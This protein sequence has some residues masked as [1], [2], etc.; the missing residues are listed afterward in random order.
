MGWNRALQKNNFSSSETLLFR[1]CLDCF[2][3]AQNLYVDRIGNLKHCFDESNPPSGMRARDLQAWRSTP[4]PL[5]YR[6]LASREF[7][8]L[9]LSLRWLHGA[10]V[11]PGLRLRKTIFLRPEKLFFQ[12]GV[13][14]TSEMK[15]SSSFSIH[16]P[17]DQTSLALQEKIAGSE[18]CFFALKGS[19]QALL[20]KKNRDL[21]HCFFRFFSA[22]LLWTQLQARLSKKTIF[23]AVK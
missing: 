3:S 22:L 8:L 13:L 11:W 2:Q 18:N 7:C 6:T 21:K 14:L 12:H 10:G 23:Q 17:N 4:W 9:S 16:E 19:S 1:T 15:R 5:C 20:K